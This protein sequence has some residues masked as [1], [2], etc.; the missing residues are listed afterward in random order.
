MRSINLVHFSTYFL[1]DDDTNE[2]SDLWNECYHRQHVTR[3]RVCY[4]PVAHDDEWRR[5]TQC[6]RKTCR[7]LGT[8]KP[9]NRNFLLLVLIWYFYEEWHQ[10]EGTWAR[11]SSGFSFASQTA[12]GNALVQIGR[13]SGHTDAQLHVR[14]EGTAAARAEWVINLTGATVC[15]WMRPGARVSGQHAVEKVPVK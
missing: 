10:D 11:N 6:R 9:Q 15:L 1:S 8:N 5:E 7:V 14:T 13:Q 2:E 4:D 12:P 3:V